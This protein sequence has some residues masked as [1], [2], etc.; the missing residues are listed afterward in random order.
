[1][2]DWE[3]LFAAGGLSMDAFAAAVGCGA[4]KSRLRLGEVLR[5]ALVFGGFQALMPLLGCWIGTG[6][7]R[8]GERLGRWLAGGVL[9]WIGGDMLLSVGDAPKNQ[10]EFS[11]I[12]LLSL[13]LSTSVDAF[14]AGAAFAALRVAPLPAA[15]TIGLVT[16]FV[17]GAGAVLGRLFGGR[18]GPAAECLGGALLLLLGMDSFL[19]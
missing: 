7:G 18:C 17:S 19:P 6:L 16:A 5:L 15:V 10:K 1:M 14:A 12:A 11:G 9:L 4:G 8:T 3:M 13:A 2:S